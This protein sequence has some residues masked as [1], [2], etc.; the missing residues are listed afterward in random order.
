[1]N[2][3]TTSSPSEEKKTTPMMLQWHSCKKI[4][5]EAVLFFRMGDFYEAFYD[6]A[7]LISKKI[8]LTLTK[9]QGIPMCGIP[10]HSSEAYIDKLVALGLCVAIAEQTEDPKEAKG[11]VKREVVRIITPGTTYSQHLVPDKSN[12][13][14]VSI[15]QVGSIFGLAILDL[16]TAEFEV[17]EFEKSKDLLNELFKIKPSECLCSER[18]AQRNDSLIVQLK[19]GLDFLLTT[20]DSFYFT[21]ETSYSNL[22][23]HFDIH[24]LDAFG[25]KGKVAGINASGALLYYLKKDLKLSL[26]HLKTLKTYQLSDY[27]S[28]DYSTQK[29]LELTGNTRD[30]SRKN[31]LLSVLDYTHTAM[32]GRL[33]QRWIKQPLLSIDKITQRLDAI[34]SFLQNTCYEEELHQELKHVQ[35]L[36]RILM[37]VSTGFAGPRDLLALKVSLRQ[38][39]SIKSHLSSMQSPLLQNLRNNLKEL[40]ELTSLLENAI[41]DEAPL[42][43]SDGGFVKTGFNA[44]L[45]ELTK[46]RSNTQG[47]LLE[48]QE[49]IRKETNIKSLKVGYTR[50]FGYYIEVSKAQAERMPS[51]FTRRQTLVNNERFISP[52]LKEFET[53]IL[54]AE[55]QISKIESALFD[56]FKEKVLEFEQSIFC[57]AQAIANIDVLQSLAYASSINNYSRP[58]FSKDPVLN[59]REGRHPVLETLSLN[60]QFIPN[61]TVMDDK[62]QKL[63]IITGPNMAGKSTYIRQVALIVIMAQLGCYVPAEKATLGITD[64]VFS[65]IGASDDLSRGQ[66]T[67]M[68]EMNET[69]NILNNATSSSLVILDEIGRGTSTYDGISIAWA[70][71]EYLL[72]TPGKSPKTLFATHYWEL[73]ELEKR[74][75]GAV[76]YSIAVKEWND[77]IVFLHKIVRGGTDKSYGIQVARLAGLPKAAIARA[78]EI[79][80]KLEED[81]SDESS[82]TKTPSTQRKKKSG[83]QYLLFEPSKP[84]E[85]KENNKLDKLKKIVNSVDLNKTTPMEAL[86]LLAKLKEQLLK[87]S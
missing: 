83:E 56:S 45:D 76:N 32:G 69:A 6:D 19:Q 23:E 55:E 47:F 57:I 14:F 41:K 44:D 33:I 85:A 1:M 72:T 25:L 79:L 52:E 62:N 61:E 9:R 53:K 8:N 20:R 71:A 68:V 39:P 10:H 48:Y 35:D 64:K 28:L 27:V 11:L 58:S 67:F 50:V 78:K 82:S 51:S 37:K 63:F 4:S 36:E 22:Q 84:L 2:S 40:K 49:K 80:N 17:I 34:D 7:V 3:K 42:R 21:H 29:H 31:T 87:K 12:N 54:N 73:T 81:R 18:F 38:L 86:N 46:L 26:N 74:V 43:A 70:V 59:I 65:R 75:K 13:F 30:G 66:S 15:D 77:E 60:G 16:S 24:S 5:K